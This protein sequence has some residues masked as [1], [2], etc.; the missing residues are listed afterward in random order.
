MRR[1]AILTGHMAHQLRRPSLLWVADALRTTGWHVTLVTVGYSWISKLC[2]DARLAALPAPPRSG[3]VAPGLE[4]VFGYAPIHPFSTGRDWLDEGLRPLHAGFAAYWRQ[5]LVRALAGSE[6]VIVESG[7]PLLLA[8][9]ARSAAPE[10]RLIYRVNDDIA[11]LGAPRWM[12]RAEPRLARLCDRLSTAS[13]RLAE[14][15]AHPNVTIDPMGL[16]AA[17]LT[18][19]RPD[20][21]TPRARVEAVCAGTT[22]IDLS[23]LCRLARARPRWRLHV[24][25]RLP[26]PADLPANLILHGEQSFEVTL[27]HIQHADVGLAAYRDRPGVAY[28]ADNS[29]RILLYRHTGLPILGPAGLCHPSR[30]TILDWSDPA[31][32]RRCETW[33]K[34]PEPLPDWSDLARRLTAPATCERAK[35]KP[36]PSVSAVAARQ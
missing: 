19:A 27:A 2:G 10:A 20:P 36:R 31:A 8:R 14:R 15:F 6:V 3:P 7:A 34:R 11:L 28:Q 16:P 1:V 22:Q 18:R 25:G 13:P 35:P 21:F 30:P 24:L 32:L 26:R 33:E 23:A 12:V 29:N 9:A 5:R 17:D 4:A